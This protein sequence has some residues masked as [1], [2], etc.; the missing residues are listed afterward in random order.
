MKT[1]PLVRSPIDLTKPL[2]RRTTLL[3]A[4]SLASLL[5]RLTQLNFYDDLCLIRTIGRERLATQNIV[6]DLT[7]PTHVETFQQLATLTQLSLDDLYT[8]S[9]QRFAA[10]LDPL[11]Q[12]AQP[13]LWPDRTTR[14]RVNPRWARA[15]LRTSETTQFCPLCLKAAAYHRVSW[16]PR[17]A[18]IC[19]EHL[20]LLT[21]HCP[22]CWKPTTV[23]DLVYCRCL[24]CEADL[25]RARRV[26]IAHDS[27]S[28]RSQQAIQH[29]L[30]V[31]DVPDE[32]WAA[33][34]LPP[35]PPHVLY[36]LLQLFAQQLVKGQVDW[37]NLPSPLNGLANSVAATI[38]SDRAL[39][40]EQAYFLYRSAFAALLDWP[41]GLHRWLDA[42][43]GCQETAPQNLMRPQRIREVQREWLNADWGDAPL[44][45]VQR[46][47]L[48]YV[49]KRQWPLAASAVRQLKDVSWFVEQSDLWTEECTAH[50]LDLPVADLRRFYPHGSLAEC[51][52]P[53]SQANLIRFK[54][55]GIL[56]VKQRWRE[57]WSLED[58]SSWLGVKVEDVQRLVEVGLLP[59][60]DEV[61]EI[62]PN[63]GVFSP[64]V[65]RDFFQ[66]IVTH[67]Q[68]Y[69]E[70]PSDLILMFEAVSEVH[71]LGIDLA[72][73][74]QSILAGVLPACPHHPE[75][76]SLYHID[77]SQA[78][79][80]GLPDQLYAARGYVSADRFAYDYGFA[81][82][83]IREWL[84]AGLIQPALTF[85]R[86]D[87]FDLQQLKELA[88]QHGF[89]APIVRPVK[90][91]RNAR[92]WDTG[93]QP[94]SGSGRYRMP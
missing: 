52:W 31:A 48:N 51:Y 54:R 82:Y 70:S 73:L 9:D 12:T 38:E 21:D 77:F 55:T 63:R 45:F 29:W 15:Q 36:Q 1:S 88:A 25:R 43:G 91:R 46:E 92:R 40:P 58:A 27:L 66:Q 10:W 89:V 56:A 19:L 59:A 37:P 72:V 64:Q 7:Q 53:H 47:I 23:A 94:V 50:T 11:D 67:L 44:A 20:C 13:M 28:V 24:N 57:G 78:I 75:I 8:A 61:N 41:D 30:G 65:V 49:L 22:R 26:S 18:A 16:I 33:C 74:L 83:L 90:A 39:R 60:Q 93:T 35:R 80:F 84:V 79:I 68:P 69:P 81:S 32:T 17:A 62:D 71:D 85:S 86:H 5:E 87:Y 14:P 4:E 3:P 6:D 42:Y 2:L 34:H 76:V